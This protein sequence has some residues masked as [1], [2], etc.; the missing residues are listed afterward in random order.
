MAG[1][2]DR[3]YASVD[4]DTGELILCTSKSYFIPQITEMA[5]NALFVKLA[6][7]DGRY[8]R[9]SNYKMRANA[10]KDSADSVW[11]IMSVDNVDESGGTVASSRGSVSVSTPLLDRSLYVH[12]EHCFPEGRQSTGFVRPN[13]VQAFMTRPSPS[14]HKPGF[15]LFCAKL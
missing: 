6:T 5:G 12:I 10:F 1:S 13:P 3:L 7:S 15:Y 2:Q 8:L 14:I 11:I 9:H 4:E